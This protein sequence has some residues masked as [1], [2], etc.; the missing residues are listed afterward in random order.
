MNATDVK[1][2][3]KETLAREGVTIERQKTDDKN[4]SM[5]RNEVS[6]VKTEMA[7]S[8]VDNKQHFNDER[9]ENGVKIETIKDKRS[10]ISIEN[11]C[12]NI[13]DPI[14]AVIID[15]KLISDYHL[16]NNTAYLV[17]PDCL[18]IGATLASFKGEYKVFVVYDGKTESPAF[19]KALSYYKTDSILDECSQL[20]IKHKSTNVE[21]LNRDKLAELVNSS[22]EIADA[23]EEAGDEIE[24]NLL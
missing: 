19:E 3:K 2:I 14:Y 16:I 23:L 10:H 8:L 5:V 6:D 13:I 9:V 4:K 12:V 1:N 15:D 11:E 20:I 18:L 7:N 21:W 24:K 22:T 17:S